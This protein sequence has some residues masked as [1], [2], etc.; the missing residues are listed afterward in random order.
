MPITN[1]SKP[2]PLSLV[3]K[4]SFVSLV[5]KID[6]PSDH[7]IDITPK[8]LSILVTLNKLLVVDNF[9]FLLMNEC[10]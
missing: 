5:L 3:W 4:M 2:L 7:L 1:Y 8:I 6:G 10:K 9:F